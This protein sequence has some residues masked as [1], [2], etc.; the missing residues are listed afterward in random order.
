MIFFLKN[1]IIGTLLTNQ[2]PT[3]VELREFDIIPFLNNR[4]SLTKN[5]FVV[6]QFCGVLAQMR[7]A[8]L[9]L[10]HAETS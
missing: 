8:L 7:R 6:A 1:V 10:L 5:R 3:Y 4:F 9:R 2:A